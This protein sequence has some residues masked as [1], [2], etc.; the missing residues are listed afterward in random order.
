MDLE[1][2]KKSIT[3]AK[4]LADYVMISMHAHDMQG[5]K[6]ENHAQY[7]EELAHKCVDFGADAVVGHGPHLIGAVEVYMVTKNTMRRIVFFILN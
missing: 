2:I 5:M 7:I 3:E 6:K 4:F 1:R